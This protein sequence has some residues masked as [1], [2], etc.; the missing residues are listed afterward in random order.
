[1]ALSAPAAA[2]A[3][4]KRDLSAERPLAV[5]SGNDIEH[6]LLHLG[7]MYAGVPY[8]PISPAYSLLSSD[9]GKLRY[10]FDLMTPGLVFAS[11]RK[12]FGK[13]IDA[14]VPRGTEVLYALEEAEPTAAV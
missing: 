13:A 14:V 8:A 7:A 1:M 2:S 10:I 11:D 5:L 12:A 3:W 9:F 6:A 4:L